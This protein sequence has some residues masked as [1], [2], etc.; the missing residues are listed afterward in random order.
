MSGNAR[1]EGFHLGLE[2]SCSAIPGPGVDISQIKGR[3]VNAGF[4]VSPAVDSISLYP[5]LTLRQQSQ[6][7]ELSTTQLAAYLEGTGQQLSPDELRFLHTLAVER[8]DG[9]NESQ[10]AIALSRRLMDIAAQRI[11]S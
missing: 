2:L 3:C 10:E 7:Q 8:I 6:L 1:N 9:S 4:V 11:A 5:Q